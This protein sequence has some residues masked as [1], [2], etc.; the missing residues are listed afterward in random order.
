MNISTDKAADPV[1]V[2]GYT[3][4]L[5]ER[6]TAGMVD[7]SSGVYLS[8]RFG[9]VLGSRGSVLPTFR[10]ADRSRRSGDRH[11]PGR[12]A[13]LHDD[14][15]S[16]SLVVQAGGVGE[17]GEVLVL[18]MGSPVRIDDV[19]RRL[20]AQSG[21]KVEIEYTGLRQGEKLHERLLG[22]HEVGTIRSH[23]TILHTCVA[24]LY[25][26]RAAVHHRRDAG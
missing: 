17:P 7:S 21:K 19:A 22:A 1:S 13:V 6:L 20:I 11:P 12:D 10:R 2:L 25:S 9:N 23:P 26:V 8:V 14:G 15:G 5:A 18:D 16:R 4:H 24:P 3:K